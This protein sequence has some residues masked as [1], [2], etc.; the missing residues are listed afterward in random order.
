MSGTVRLFETEDAARNAADKLAKAGFGNCQV[1]VASQLAGQEEAAVRAAA[2]DGVLPGAHINS[3]IS[4]LKQ[5]RS[6]VAVEA[7]FGKAKRAVHIMETNGAVESE[8]LPAYTTDDPSPFSDLIGFP[9]L[10]NVKPS[11][12]L[13]RHDWTFSSMFGLGLLSKNQ[14]GSDRSFG[15]K[16]LVPHVD[17][18]SFGMSLLSKDQSGPSK[19]FGFNTLSAGK[20]KTKLSS[21]P[22]PFSSLFGMSTLT[23]RK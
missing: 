4:G 22:A 19:S 2:A 6:L 1:L 21:N 11:T 18:S 12:S 3:S 5:G 16:T 7:P 15:M 9:T 14:K 23:N 13:A 8:S 10:S 17:K 20:S